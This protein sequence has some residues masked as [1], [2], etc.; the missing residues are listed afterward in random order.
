[1]AAGADA[2]A[3]AAAGSAGREETADAIRL[4]ALEAREGRAFRLAGWLSV[5]AGLIWPFQA[6]VIAALVA[7]WLNQRAGVEDAVTSALA[8]LALAALRALIEHRAG[9]IVFAAADRVVAAER[10]A[11]VARESRRAEGGPGS[12]ALGALLAQK[13]PMLLPYLTR[14]RPARLRTVVLPAVILL[15]TLWFSWAAALI[16]V[17][18]GPMIPAFM[19]LIGM[20]AREASQKQMAEIGDLN[21]LLMERLGAL[22]D[23]R[24]LDA[25]GRTARDFEARAEGL[26]QRTMAVLRIA[27]LSS[28]VLELFAS[29]GIAMVAVF[30]GFSLLGYLRFGTWAGPLGA[31]E[32]IFLLLLAPEFFQPLRDVA[33]AWHDRAAALAVAGE[34]A[35]AEA[36]AV[37]PVA[38]L[39]AGGPAARLSG[40]ASVVVRDVEIRRGGRGLRLPELSLDA[41]ERLAVTGLSGS[42]KSTLL[43][44]V[45]GLVPV[46]SGA[47]LVAGAPLSEANADAWRARIA[48]VG[49]APH[50]LDRSLA[51][52]LDPRGTGA[53]LAPAL[54]A[55]RAGDVVARLPGGLQARLGE[56]G[57]GIS[58]GEARRLMLARALAAG[59]DL[60]L[61]DEP[62]ADLDPETADA[63][64]S[65]L[66]ALG[67]KGVGLIVATHDP[68]L[69]AAMG[70]ELRL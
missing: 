11:A 67:V 46:A 60:V 2:G 70:R 35:G 6:W 43:A 22:V 66:M 56:S 55:A 15:I 3:G 34:L 65:A 8:F 17:V 53:D 16:L 10:A 47:V 63:V 58:G 49:Q 25:G 1:M 51:E 30:V 21:T 28:T 19:A 38:V 33:A 14:Y 5:T 18:A 31:G 24:L 57:G 13:L 68:A 48:W 9:G 37:A 41:G 20:K 52:N 29:L 32:G 69:I 54:E 40:P 23:I 50:F 12:A 64:I 44:A 45:A 59:P 27:F 4:E 39:G 61:A 26:R 42:G 7:S 62:T 36:A